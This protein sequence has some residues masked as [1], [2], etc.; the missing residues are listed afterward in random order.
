MV[1]V[2]GCPEWCFG[3]GSHT[4]DD[5]GIGEHAEFR[6]TRHHQ[7]QDDEAT[8]HVEQ[9]ETLDGDVRT[10]DPILIRIY[11]NDDDLHDG[12]AANRIAAEIM[13]AADRWNEIEAAGR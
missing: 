7:D 2:E 11:V 5:G 6:H 13:N 4:W 1:P 9:Y 8:A 3:R 10:L 12:P